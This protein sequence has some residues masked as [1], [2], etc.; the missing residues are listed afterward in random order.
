MS[1]VWGPFMILPWWICICLPTSISSFV[2]QPHSPAQTA[3]IRWQQQ[4]RLAS[5]ISS[6]SSSAANQA[7]DL[8]ENDRL[9][10]WSLQR[11]LKELDD[12]GI[13]YPVTASR[14]DL[15]Q[16]FLQWKA[17]VP[18]TTKNSENNS[19]HQFPSSSPTST[20]LDPGLEERLRKRR[21]RRRRYHRSEMIADTPIS[22]QNE[23]PRRPSTTV[24]ATS[25][26]RKTVTERIPRTARNVVDRGWRITKKVSRKARDWMAIDEDGVRDV[27]FQYLD[28]RKNQTKVPSASSP[29]TSSKA[30]DEDDNIP[31]VHVVEVIT[32][33]SD[34]E[35]GQ[36]GVRQY[37][38]PLSKQSRRYVVRN[39]ANK[40]RQPRPRQRV[41]RTHRPV[42]H[43]TTSPT[44]RPQTR[45]SASPFAKQRTT[46]GEPKRRKTDYATTSSSSSSSSSSTSKTLEFREPNKKLP[47][48]AHASTGH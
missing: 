7:F 26:A 15:E 17:S 34:K 30:V 27:S 37:D 3:S 20:T 46:T 16:L 6:T 24:A 22:S 23:F 5:T 31:T 25:W 47:W 33:K 9:S 8:G 42:H 41:V 40:T 11:L 35:I 38:M 18:Q 39:V 32:T 1:L 48:I 12:R 43:S 14:T 29:T 28:Q 36:N 13:R 45:A 19:K 44:I 2:V 21:N 10:S 4:Q